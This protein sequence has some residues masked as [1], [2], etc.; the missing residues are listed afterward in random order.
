MFM[1][2]EKWTIRNSSCN[3]QGCDNGCPWMEQQTHRV[4]LCCVLHHNTL[5]TPPALKSSQF[6]VHDSVYNG[7]AEFSQQE[8]DWKVQQGPW[9]E[10]YL[11]SN[12]LNYKCI[13]SPLRKKRSCVGITLMGRRRTTNHLNKWDGK[14]MKTRIQAAN[15]F[16]SDKLLNIWI[17]RYTINLGVTRI[18][19]I[20]QNVFISDT[21]II[22]L[23]HS[24][25]CCNKWQRQ[26]P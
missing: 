4:Q 5:C 9:V 20:L 22:E 11:F 6:N 16:H 19:K 8:K 10:T 24:V 21:C 23:P 25:L 1:Y 14:H 17:Q 13:S 15:D 26:W 2:G 12:F 18:C 7:K 3:Q